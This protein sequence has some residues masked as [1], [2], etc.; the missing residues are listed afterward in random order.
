[1][2]PLFG[3]GI[4]SFLF[5]NFSESTSFSI[6]SEIDGQVQKYMPFVIVEDFQMREMTTNPNQFYIYIKYSIQSLNVLDEL[7]FV[8]SK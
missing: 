6:R 8:V 2:D 5:E 1:M 3:V 4:Q 7:S